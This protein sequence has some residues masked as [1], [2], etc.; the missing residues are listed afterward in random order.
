MSTEQNGK[1]NMTVP[2]I[3]AHLS[4]IGGF[5]KLKERM[6]EIGATCCSFFLKNQKRFNSKPIDEKDLAIFKTQYYILEEDEPDSFK[7]IRIRETNSEQNKDEIK[8]EP[9]DESENISKNESVNISKNE[10]ENIS[11]N[12]SGNISKD[13]SGNV[14]K[15]EKSVDDKISEPKE[16]S[17]TNDWTGSQNIDILVPHAS[18][19]INMANATDTRESH[20]ECFY[21]ELKRCEQLGIR[22]LNIHPGSD[23]S[24]LG[25]KKAT[26]LIAEA[27]NEG[28]KRNKTLTILLENMAG[29]GNVLCSKF[30]EIKMIIDKVVDKKRIGVCI[31]TAHL[32]GAGYDIR[33]KEKYDAVIEK[34]D[35]IIGLKYVKAMH[36]NDSMVE[37]NTK[38][39]RHEQIGKGYIGKDAFKFIMQ[40]KRLVAIPKIL[41]T[42]DETKYKEEIALL[43]KFAEES[44]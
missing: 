17:V 18:Y 4:I 29:Q 43:K 28:H 22:Y 37:I 5:H 36:L 14:P 9:E 7:R 16:I 21:D 10:S 31:D 11:K 27:V 33:T 35:Q 38:K 39:D 40:D 6:L 15:D 26:D 2:L 30:D 23:T 8:K 42:P 41:E 20:L 44:E 25:I 12:D 3:G 24:K 34:I 19:L 1:K 32:F 13:E